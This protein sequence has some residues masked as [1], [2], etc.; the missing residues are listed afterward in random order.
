M[1]ESRLGHR[2]QKQV[3]TCCCMTLRELMKTQFGFLIY[4]VKSVVPVSYDML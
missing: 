2:I 3:A 4:E 1:L